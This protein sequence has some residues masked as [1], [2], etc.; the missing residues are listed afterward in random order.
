[1]SLGVNNLLTNDSFSS[2]DN[3][4]Y[5]FWKSHYFELGSNN[6][7]RLFKKGGLFYVDFGLSVIYSVL[8]A[9]RDQF[10]EV[11]GNATN[12]QTHP[13]NLDKSKFKIVQLISP[14]Y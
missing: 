5:N 4:E 3:S 6:K 14:A 10:F 9:K 11:V 12:L 13:N 7:T 8:N 1:M 2:L